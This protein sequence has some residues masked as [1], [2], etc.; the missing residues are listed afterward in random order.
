MTFMNVYNTDA[1]KEIL[2]KLRKSDIDRR[3]SL[4]KA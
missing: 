4:V 3:R 2:D 1:Y